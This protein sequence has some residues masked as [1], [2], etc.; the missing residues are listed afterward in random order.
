MC[1][2]KAE[3]SVWVLSYAI[4][5]LIFCLMRLVEVNIL[6]YDHTEKHDPSRVFHLYVPRTEYL[7]QAIKQGK[8]YLACWWWLRG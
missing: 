8:R 3:Q 2:R 5:D 1:L 6:H 7:R 4:D